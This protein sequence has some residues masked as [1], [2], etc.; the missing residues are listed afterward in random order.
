MTECGGVERVHTQRRISARVARIRAWM[1]RM[2]AD[3]R[4]PVRSIRHQPFKSLRKHGWCFA[5]PIV[6]AAAVAAAAAAA[7]AVVYQAWE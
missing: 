2:G 3:N 7:A 4:L 6:T 1:Q 5:V